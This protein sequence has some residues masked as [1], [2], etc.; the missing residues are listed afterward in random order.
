[1]LLVAGHD[2]IHTSAVNRVSKTLTKSILSDTRADLRLTV[3]LWKSGVE[4]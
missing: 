4:S 1:M 3:H 2:G